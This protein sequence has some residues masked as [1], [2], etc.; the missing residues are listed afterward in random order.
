MSLLQQLKPWDRLYEVIGVLSPIFIFSL[1]LS[2]VVYLVFALL[3]PWIGNKANLLT[4]RTPPGSDAPKGSIPLLRNPIVQPGDNSEGQFGYASSF[5]YVLV[6]SLFGVVLGMLVK[7]VGG[8]TAL[9]SNAPSNT[10]L[11]AIGSIVIIALGVAGSLFADTGR[12][13]LRRPVGA[14]AFLVSF[15]VSGFY[16]QFLKGAIEG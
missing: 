9:T 2:V 11:G 5:S 4:R 6:A 14:I 8:F 3:L 15:L 12:I 13:P 10:V 7:L 1:L 16:W